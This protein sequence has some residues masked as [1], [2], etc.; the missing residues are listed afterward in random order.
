[1]TVVNTLNRQQLKQ[2][3]E[4]ATALAEWTLVRDFA[5][6][7][8]G[9]GRAAKVSIDTY[10]EY[11]DEGGTYYRI[12]DVTAYDK[13]GNV[14]R[15]DHSLPFFATKAWNNGIEPYKS[16]EGDEDHDDDLPLFKE[17]YLNE[18]EQRQGWVVFDDLPCNE[19]GDTYILTTQP[20]LSLP[21]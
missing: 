12:E 1:M 7:M 11:N 13:D 19:D 20:V 18:E 17:L 5:N 9:E 4:Q 6:Q 8:Y 10:G 2:L 16:D 21:A 3:A 15:F 14:L